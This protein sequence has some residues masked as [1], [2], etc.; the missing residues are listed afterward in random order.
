VGDYCTEVE[1]N[2][3]NDVEVTVHARPGGAVSGKVS[4][5]DGD[6][7]PNILI[8]VLRRQGK[9]LLPIF[10]G[11]SPSTLVRMHTDDRGTYR[12]TGLPPG[13][14]LIAAAETHTAP[15]SRTRGYGGFDE[16]FMSDALSSTY[17]GG[18]GSLK[19]ATPLN[20]ELGTEVADIDIT[21]AE[22]VTHALGGTVTARVDG[23]VLPGAN[24]S[25]TNRERP[26]WQ[27]EGTRQ[28]TT[29]K[30]G[31]WVFAE[32][33]DGTY[34]IKVSPPYS[35]PLAGAEVEPERNPEEE[36]R[37]RRMRHFVAKEF[38]VTISGGDVIG[39]AVELAEGATISGV[40]ELPP[41]PKPDPAEGDDTFIMIRWTYDGSQAS[42]YPNSGPAYGGRFKLEGVQPGKIYL[43]ASVTRRGIPDKRWYVKSIT[44]NGRDVMT[45]PLIVREGET[46]QGVRIVIAGDFAAGEILLV[47]QGG[48]PISKKPVYIV[49][50]D[51]ALWL[52]QDGIISGFTDPNGAFSFKAPPGEYLV[53]L[54]KASE[55]NLS[56]PELMRTYAAAAPHL[57]LESGQN[58]N[59]IITATP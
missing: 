58:K 52:S 56:W 15:D 44:L 29:D 6:P 14:Y 11:I 4:Y 22:V 51:P 18:S 17:Y 30:E 43:N 7:A 3:D 21:L 48:K 54:P 24:I 45:K 2:D 36:P 38:D 47:D 25:I 20:I 16:L 1:V 55:L 32:V 39:L 41:A 19:D 42:E 13:E 5:A 28:T 12:I 26:T 59:Q 27:R 8:N 34:A 49:P 53:I 9:E 40:V 10:T 33:P 46:I 35:V 57:K 23:V 50:S 31:K 37:E